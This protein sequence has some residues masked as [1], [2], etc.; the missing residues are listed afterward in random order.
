MIDKAGPGILRILPLRPGRRVA[1]LNSQGGNWQEQVVLPARQA[2]PLP[3]DLPEE[4]AAS[5]F[6]NPA[7]AVVMTRSVLKVKPGDWL[8]QTAA[9][10][11]LGRMVIRLSQH[12]GF[13]TINVVRRQE[14]VS[15]IKKLGGTEVIC[16][17]E[18]S[19]EQRALKITHGAGVP[20]ALDAV[21]GSTGLG[22]LRSLVHNG[23]MLVY[24]LLSGE[25]IPVEPR[26]LMMGQK[27]I[28]GFWLSEW[29]RK[30]GIFTMLGL[31]RQI[32][33]LLQHQVLTTRRRTLCRSSR[34]RPQ[35]ARRNCRA[36]RG[37]C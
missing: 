27:S 32:T 35:C 18:E 6:V 21:G 36:G 15:E 12:F 10:S 13:R 16:S 20:Y 1:V 29:V 14:Q 2:V 7:S 8:L 26:F 3:Q 4:Q 34:F 30:Q 19:I 9:R 22:A 11:A 31:F 33:Q 24:G 23:R 28:E 17:S 5:F 37:R 25:P